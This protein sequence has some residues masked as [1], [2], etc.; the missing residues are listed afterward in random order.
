MEAWLNFYEMP[1]DALFLSPSAERK[2]N[3]TNKRLKELDEVKRLQR[4]N[5]R[6]RSACTFF[7]TVP[8]D[9]SSLADWPDLDAQIVQIP[10][11]ESEL[12]RS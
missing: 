5:G 7:D 11:F 1:V 12:L 10:H 6:I 8:K 4:S 9:Y 3:V 2:V